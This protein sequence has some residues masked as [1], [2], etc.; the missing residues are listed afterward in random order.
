MHFRFRSI[1]AAFALLL[2]CS[3][4][5]A[6]IVVTQS[7]FQFTGACSD[8]T[9]N[10]IGILTLQNYTQ[11][12]LLQPGNFVSF[13][14]TSNLTNFTI[15]PSSTSFSVNGSLP[16]S[17]P[18]TASVQIAGNGILFFSLT[19]GSWCAGPS[20]GLDTGTSS[21][22]GPPSAPPT[23]SASPA[24]ALSDWMLVFLAVALAVMGSI[25]V[26]RIQ[27]RKAA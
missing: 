16:A 24:P 11:G 2:L 15:T 26:K 5:A 22:W 23:I 10:G 9:G 3:F 7:T 13:T 14:Y 17:L 27:A 8:C 12:R 1:L 20:C 18:A 6:P 4:V 19:N 21:T 25:L